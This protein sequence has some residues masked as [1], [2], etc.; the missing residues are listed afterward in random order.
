MVH[1][2]AVGVVL[3]GA[4]LT[5]GVI[6]LSSSDGTCADWYQS[7]RTAPTMFSLNRTT[8]RRSPRQRDRGQIRTPPKAERGCDG[9]NFRVS[10]TP[11]G[12][13]PPG[14]KNFPLTPP[15]KYI[16]A[17]EAAIELGLSVSRVLRLC[18]HGLIRGAWKK[19]YK[20]AIPSPVVRLDRPW[21]D[22]CVR[23]EEAARELEVTRRRVWQ[24]C[25]LGRIQGARLVL[26]RWAIPSPVERLDV[27]P[28]GCLDL[29]E[30]AKE[31]G[32]TRQRVWELC[33]L[34]RIQGARVILGKWAIPSP[35]VRLPPSPLSRSRPRTHPP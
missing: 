12:E 10:I 30:A 7:R 26:G 19:N 34:G 21:P 5:A 13:G 16:A 2:C 31:L 3:L 1:F 9:A 27:R 15:T 35:V 4:R 29:E 11:A 14:I 22:R 6:G 18:Q 20:W 24:L 32:V 8:C 28:D 25:Q 33:Q 17:H 23:L